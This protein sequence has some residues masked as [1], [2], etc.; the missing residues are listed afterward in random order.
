MSVEGEKI[1]EGLKKWG[2]VETPEGS[3]YLTR[4]GTW[5][6]GVEKNGFDEDHRPQMSQA[7]SH[8]GIRFT[9]QEGKQLTGGTARMQAAMNE[10]GVIRARVSTQ[11]N[12]FLNVDLPTSPSSSQVSAIKDQMIDMDISSNDL[13]IDTWERDSTDKADALSNRFKRLFDPDGFGSAATFEGKQGVWRTVRGTPI[14]IPEGEDIKDVIDKQFKAKGPIKTQTKL[15]KEGV[16]FPE[17]SKNHQEFVKGREDQN[18]TFDPT[19]NKGFDAFNESSAKEFYN[20]NSDGKNDLYIISTTNHQGPLSRESESA[21]IQV[22]NEGS[23]PLIGHWV[24]DDTGFDYTDVSFPKNEGMNDRGAKTLLN[25]FSQE[26]ALVISP[27]GKAR[28]LDA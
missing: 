16:R 15:K 22:K 7:L 27:N 2:T 17:A 28:F 10:S 21:F 4:D 20:A 19:T 1:E 6:G 18:Y 3:V 11:G 25:K 24:S 9:N 14:F 13:T 5:I 26:S 8:A 23:K 12:N